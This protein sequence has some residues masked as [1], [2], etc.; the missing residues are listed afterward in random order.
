MIVSLRYWQMIVVRQIKWNGKSSCHAS[1]RLGR[2]VVACAL[3]IIL[4]M[5]ALPVTSEPLQKGML[6][7]LSLSGY[8]AHMNAPQFSSRTSKGRMVSLADLRGRVVLLTFWASWC[9]ECRP[10]MPAFEQLHRDFTA[11]GLTV[12]GV[13]VREGK[14]AIQSYARELDLT[15]PLVLDS[16][17]EIRNSYGVIG[18]PTTFLIGR[19]GRTVGLAVGPR[20]WSSMPARAIIQALLTESVGSKVAP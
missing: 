20:E 2:G 14:R 19:D 5:L 16:N 4:N 18:L 3:T 17:G 12:L 7:A 15:F 9:Q 1:N 8:P 10:E 13:N 11:Q 6:E